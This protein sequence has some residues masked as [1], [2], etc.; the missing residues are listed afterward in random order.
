VKTT[1][2]W[3]FRNSKYSVTLVIAYDGVLLCPLTDEIAIS[4]PLRLYKLKLALYVCANQKKYTSA[5]YAVILQYTIRKRWAIIGPSPQKLVEINCNQIV[6]QCITRVYTSDMRTERTL[7]SL[8]VIRI[9]EIIVS[10]W[11][12]T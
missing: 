5:L 2:Y 6:L 10:I 7:R 1:T 9:A 8:H 3:A 12:C 4:D 11:V